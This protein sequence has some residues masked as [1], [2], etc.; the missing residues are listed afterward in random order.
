MVYGTCSHNVVTN[1]LISEWRGVEGCEG[2]HEG[3]PGP[4][5]K[6]KSLVELVIEAKVQ[7]AH[8]SGEQAAPHPAC[9]SHMVLTFVASAVLAWAG[10]SA[11]H[12]PAF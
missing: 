10:G 11:V 8:A 9:L 7:A 2:K 1:N 3:G 5:K 12:E 6:R 4:E